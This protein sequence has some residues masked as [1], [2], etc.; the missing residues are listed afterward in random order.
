MHPRTVAL[1]VLLP[2]AASVSAQAPP[3]GLTRLL[4][5]QLA[6]FPARTGL[7]V[8]H[9]GTGEEAA[10]RGDE[11]FSSASVI[12]LA[13][14]VRAFQLAEAK[15]LDLNERVTIRRADLRDGSGVLQYHDLGLTPTYRDLI[16]EMIITSDNT[17][18]DLMVRKIGGVEALNAWLTASGF[19]HT[20]MVGRGHE[21][22][23]RLLT[24]I[25][26]EFA[27]LTPEETTGLQYASQ[28]SA[29]FGLYTD[30]F[31]GNR[32]K[33]VELVRDPA[34]RRTLAQQR[35]RLTVQDRAYWL[36]DMTP[37]ETGRLLEA[38]E[39]GTLTSKA[40]AAEMKT[41]LGRQLAG[42]RR[43]PHFL[44]VPVAHKTGD[45][46][47]IANDVA[48]VSARSG[49]VIISFFVNGVTG[50]YGEAE[51]RMGHAAREIVKYFDGAA[52]PRPAALPHYERMVLLESTAETSANVSIG[53]VNGD[54]NPDLVLA[55]GRH[56]PLVDRVL[57]G[58][59]RGGFPRAHDLGTASDRSY[60]GH[61]VDL[62]GDGDLDVAIS[63]D[64]DPKLVYLN[65]GT[66]HFRLASHFG[67][68]DWPTRNA[69]V[70]DLNGDRLPDIV[71][72]NRTGD[73]PGASYICFNKGRGQFDGA[74]EKFA[75]ESA[76][77]ITA[78]DVT[79]DGLVDLVVP[80]RDGGQSHVYVNGGTGT[81][82]G[83]ARVPFGPAN[84][85]IR[86]S[87]A[88]DLNGDGRQ[89]L[90]T[91][92]EKTGVAVY[93][94]E[95]GS[96]L[97]APV[98]IGL[99]DK[100]PYALALGD[101]DGDGKTDIV[102]G[103]IKAR[104]AV[105]FNDGSGRQFTAVPFGDDQGTAYGLAIGD[106]D[107]D[108]RL[109]IAVARSEAPNVLY[110]GGAAGQQTRSP[111]PARRVIQP[112]GYKPTP[113]PLVPAILVGDTLYLSG[114]TGGDPVSGQLVP[115]GLEPEMKQIMSNLQTVLAAA[116]MTLGDV[117]AVTVYLV[118]MADFA[119][120]NEIYRSYFPD[121]YPTRSTVAVKELA[122]GA[123]LEITMTAVR[124]K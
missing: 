27:N 39:R 15:S 12:K 73:R 91:I 61:L 108:G 14:M 116:D 51:D 57:L 40:S 22:R 88:A 115:G 10:V 43:I 44:N 21:Y 45:S 89:D 113:S 77:T 69:T 9:L 72:A 8:K 117:V 13:I 62:D 4:E 84:A 121:G 119:R 18:T 30:L 102:V 114:S 66:G 105:F 99:G 7:Y 2:L 76:T 78:A 109:D 46:G 67:Q 92:D 29:L 33:W 95:A 85:N 98:P 74:C 16:T 80:H 120:F 41:I 1:I 93:F 20:R 65:D 36:G 3:G 63:N 52:P 71:V 35:S 19:T 82:A 83:A 37:R 97:S 58:D 94:G 64:R 31:T 90:V 59:G 110:F 103:Y 42:S 112:A 55:K 96:R 60:S 24:L 47:V 11:S 104:P 56:W 5:S 101:L 79:G 70:V 32:A 26:P 124:S 48:L 6:G 17:A 34:N 25:N 81:F 28:D 118:D 54:G 50:S 75:T 107:K 53:D 23:K 111:A 86:M 49:T 38:I 100:S 123:R 87:A 68:P 106:V 122:R